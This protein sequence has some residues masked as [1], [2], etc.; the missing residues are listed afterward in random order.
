MSRWRVED[1]GSGSFGQCR[2]HLPTLLPQVLPWV[3]KVRCAFRSIKLTQASHV[4]S[5]ETWSLGHGSQGLLAG[6]L[7]R[8]CPPGPDSQGLYGKPEMSGRKGPQRYLA[9]HPTLYFTRSR[10]R[11]RDLAKGTQMGR[12]PRPPSFI[13]H[14]HSRTRRAGATKSLCPKKVSRSSCGE[15]GESS[16]WGNS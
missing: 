5:P 4:K 14:S 9:H 12:R 8:P 10:E 15:C 6:S 16:C 11:E 7:T 2:A 1:R 3:R 13:L